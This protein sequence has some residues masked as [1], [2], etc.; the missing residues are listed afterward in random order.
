MVTAE[1]TS[2]PFVVANVERADL[3]RGLKAVASA[4]ERKTTIPILSHAL[5]SFEPGQIRITATDLDVTEI[6]TIPAETE[7]DGAVSVPVRRFLAAARSLP[8]GKI[9]IEQVETRTLQIGDDGSTFRFYCLGGSD[10]PTVPVINSSKEVEIDAALLRRMLARVSYAVSSEESRFQLNGALFNQSGK[11]LAIV[12]TDGHRLALVQNEI[13][14]RKLNED[15]AL[16][17]RKALIELARFTGDGIVRLSRSETHLSFRYGGRELI[18]RILEGRFPEYEK[19]IASNEAM[20]IFN[21]RDLVDAVQRAALMTGDRARA[22]RLQFS[23]GQ[24]VISA[25]NSDLGEVKVALSCEF[26]GPGLQVGINPDYLL[27]FL[28]AVDTESV[29]LAMHNET[30]QIVGYPVDGSDDRFLCVIMPMRI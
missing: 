2:A 7:I 1:M 22:I 3:V 14:K 4:S 28:A 5:L 29:R 8:T 27:Q 30:T 10:F 20:A 26:S 11:S 24:V 12:A 13:A 9:R 17:P 16:V 18:S 6:Y 15:S 21:R 25:T 19:V 23:P